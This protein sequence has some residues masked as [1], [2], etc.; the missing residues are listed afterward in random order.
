MPIWK[1]AAV[2]KRKLKNDRSKLWTEDIHCFQE[3]RNFGIAVHENF[4]VRDRL[5]NFD[6]EN[7]VLR[8]PSRP[9]FDG[10][11]GR[12]SVEGRVHLDGMETLRVKGEVVGRLHA[13]W[14]E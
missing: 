8:R 6:G 11:G 2:E 13:P 3:L 7:E 10:S 14:I 5:R 1:D 12:A 9:V 4:V